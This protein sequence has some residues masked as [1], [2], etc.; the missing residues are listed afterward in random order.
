MTLKPLASLMHRSS[1]VFFAS[2][3]KGHGHHHHLL[4]LLIFLR[5]GV[6]GTRNPPI[7]LDLEETRTLLVLLTHNSAL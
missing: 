5:W 1:S 7:H 3:R 4:A 6:G 2:S